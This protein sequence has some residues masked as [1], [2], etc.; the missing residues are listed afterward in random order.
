MSV[1]GSTSANDTVNGAT[2]T[3]TDDDA[4]PGDI[5][6]TL[7]SSAVAESA[8][9]TTITVTAA[10]G[11]STSFP[12]DKAI[13]VAVGASGDG[14]TEG[15]DYSA[16]SDFT[17]T[18]SA[19]SASVTGTFSVDPTE[20]VLDEAD[21]S[22][23]VT[24]STSANDTV[25]SASFNITDNDTSPAVTLTAS[26]T[27]VAEDVASAPTVTVTAAIPVGNNSVT[28]STDIPVTVTVAGSG[29][30]SA[31]DFTPVGNFTITLS[32]GS[33]SA[34]GT[35]VLTPTNDSEDESD[36]TVTVSG[37]ASSPSG[38]ALTVNSDTIT[39]TD[40]DGS[41]AITLT[42]SETTVVED[43]YPAP[44]V[45]V[46]ASIPSSGVKFAADTPVTVTVGASGDGATEG[47]DYS[48]VSDFTITLS[49]GS[50][51]ATGT[52]VLTPTDDYVDETDETVT[53][54]GSASSPSGTALTVNSDTITLTD[55]DDSP[56]ITLD[57]GSVTTV[58][59]NVSPAPTVTVTASIPTGGT[60]AVTFSTDVPV[61]V[62]VAGS[63]TASAVDFAAVSDFTITLS[64]GST[65]ATGTFVLTPADDNMDEADETVTVSGSAEFPSGTSLTVDS[66]TI[67]LTD[68]D[69]APGNIGLSLSSTSVAES[70]SATTITVTAALSGS[71]GFAG[72]V[73]VTV[74]VSGSGTASAVD[75]APVSDFTITLSA[76]STSAT[77]TFVLTPADDNMDETDETVTVSG[78]ASPSFGTATVDSAT[79]AL[80]DDDAAPGAIGLTLSSSAV[81]ESA[82]A[83]TITVTAALGGSTRFAAD[84]AITVAVG[85]SGDGATEG[86]DYSTVADFTITLSAGSS[87][88]TGTFSMDP[89]QDVLD[90]RTG[91]SVSVSGSTSA[92]DTVNGAS[93]T[94]TD[95]DASPGDIGLTL[96]SSAVAESASATTVTVTA[97]LGGSTRFSTDKAITVAV[98]ASGDSATEGTDYDAVSD[99]TITL[100]AGS[101]SVTG[102]FSIDPTQDA[103]D[104]GTGESVSV[105]GSTS[106]YDTVNGATLTITD[107]DAA[108]GDIGLTLSSTSVAE[109]A[110]ATTITVTAALGG[111]SRF[112]ADKAIT[113]AVGASGDGA[114]EGTDYDTVADFT[115][116]LSAGSG[117]VTGTFSIDPTQDVLDEGTG[118]SV[119]VSGSTS[120]NDTVNGATLTITDDDAAPGDIGLTLSSNAV[121]ESASATTITVTAAL[122]GTSRFT[123]DKAITVAVGASGDGATE[124]TDYDAVSD[125]TI[126]LSAGNGS[127]TG[128]FSIDPTQDVLDEGTGESV[129]VSGSTSDSDT[130]NG[131]TLTITD[132]DAAPGAIGLTLSSSAVLESASATTITVTAALGGTSRFTADKAITVAVG[133]SGDGATEGTD[134]STVDDFTITLSAGSGSV[135][136]TFSINPTQDALDEGAGESVSVSGST[137]ES[138]TV[139]GATL[140]ITDDDAAPGDIGLTLSSTSV[141]E[142]AS[143]TTITVTAAL[144]GNS[145]FTADK[146]ITVAVGASGDGATEGTDY[147]TVD[148]FTITLSAGSG[149]V[150]GTFS[151]D[152]TQDALDEGTG[153]SVSVSG[154]TS[155]NDTVN[156]AT[157]TITDDDA[158]PGDIGLTLS[159]SAVLESASATT[160]TVTAAL[161]GNSR[162][163]ADKAITVA[164]G[165]SGDGATEGTDY[166]TVDDFTITLS[167]GSGS[168]T[169]TFSIN[170][171]QDALDEGTGESV[172]VS[173]STSESDT[174]NGATLTITDDDAAPGDIGLTLSSSAVLESASATTITVTAAL[175]G[176]SRFTA[177]KAITVAVGASGDGATEG[178]DYSTVDDFTITLSAGSGSAT[179]TFSINPTQDALDEGTG[180]SVSVSGSTS[181]NDTVN[182]ATLTITDD[183]AAPGD[184][185]L[186][187]SS[188]AVL[189]S[190]SATTITVTAALGGNSRF[191][192]D[193]AITVA[194]GASGD[195]ATEGT[196]YSTVDDFTITLS[197][198]SGSVTGTF[199]IDPTQDALDEGTGE[200]V[201]VSGS[202]SAND[203]VNGATLTITDDDAAPG[204]I[205]LTL[206]SS[207]VL[208]S[209]SATTITVT[210]ALGGNSRF[211][212]DKA[213][214][215]AVGASGDGA[216]EGTDYSTVDDFTITLSAGSGSVTGTFRINPTQDALDEGTGESVSVSGSTSANDTVNAATLTITDDDAAPGDIGLTLSS[217]SVAESAS[218]TTITVTAALGGNSRFTADK[219][220]T[221]AVGAS[222]DGATEGTD[223][224]TVADFTIT[225]SAGSGSVTGTFSIDP[226]QDVL[227]EGTGESV[228]VSGSTS[229]NDT[230][231]GATLTI[232]DDDAAPGDIGLT[233]SSTSVAESASATTITVTAA[234]GGSTRFTTDKAITVAVGASGDGATEGT[235]YSTVDDFT[236]T[237][238][239]G[240]GSATGTFSIDPTQDALDEGTGESVSVSGSTSESDTVNGATL[241]ITDDDAAPGDIT[242]TLSSSAV[243]ESASAT[244]ITVTA[245]LGGNSRFTAD[246]AITVAVGA[247][248]DGATEGTDY[249]TVD[250]FTITLSA[251]SGSVTGTFSIDPTQDAL[252]EGTGESVS[253]SGSTSESDTVN[254]ATLTITDDDAAPGDIGLTLSSS[255]VL[256]SASA[257][258]ITVTAA[259]GGNS[260]FTADKAITV[261]VGASGDGATE[262]TDYSTVD[263]FTITLSAGSGSVTGTFRINPTQDALDEGTGESVSVSGSTSANDTVNAATLTITDDDAAPG[264][265]GLT[266]SS[267]SVAESA[268][269]T[270]I[271]VTAALGGNSRFTAD[272]AITVAVGASGDGATEGTDY[273]TVADFTITLSAGSGSVTGTFSI[274]P[275]Q[276]VLDEGT[277]ESVSVSGSTSAN[278]TVNGATLT[279]TDDDAAPGDIGLTLSSTSV[280]ESAS[281]TTITVTAALGG[282]TRFTTDKAITV[283]VGASGDGA[284]EGTDYSTV[285]DFTITLSAGSGSA[286]GTFSID[287]TQDALDEGT[288]ESVSVSGSTSESDTVNGATLTITDDDAAPGDI[289]LTLSPSS[290]AESASATD[291]TVTAALGGN[292]RF[293]AD[294]AITVAVGASGDGA[295]EGT[296]YSTVADFTITLSAGSGSVT[297]TFSIDPTQDDLDEGDGESVS[298]SGSTSANDTVNGATLEI[299]DDDDAPGAISLTLSKT[300]VGESASATTIT[301]TAAL[302]SNS[303]LFAEDKAIT[304]AVGASGDG[305][306]EGTDYSTVNDFT[307]TLSAGSSSA[308]GTFSID[309]TH[310]VIDEGADE[311]VTVSGSSGSLTVNPATL[312]ITDDD[313]AP[314]GLA[315]A[316]SPNSVLESASATTVTVTARTQGGTTYST[317]KA[318]TVAVG[319]SGDGATE[320]TDYAAVNDFT[321]T[322]SAGSAR[323]TGTFSLTPVDDNVYEGNETVSVSGTSDSLTISPSALTLREDDTKPP[324]SLKL[325]TVTVREN[326]PAVNVTV[327]AELPQNGSTYP[328]DKQITVV[329]GAGGS[330]ATE[331]T[332]YET[333]PDFTVTLSAGSTS[334]TGTFDFTPKDDQ[335]YEPDET[336]RVTGSAD[337]VTVS[338]ATIT[339][340]SDDPEFETPKA[341]SVADVVTD[342]SARQA[343]FTVSLSGESSKIVT[344]DYATSDGTATDGADYTGGSGSLTFAPGDT[345]KTISFSILDDSLDEEDETFAIVLANPVNATLESAAATAVIVDDDDA[346]VLSMADVTVA[347]DAGTA[348]LTASLGGPSGKTVSVD[349]AT[350]DGTA[351]SGSDYE[352]VSGSLTFAPGETEKTI[353]V[354][355]IDD[356]EV[357]SE[358]SFTVKLSGESNVSLADGSALVTIEDDD[359]EKFADRLKKV[360]EAV[361]P[362]ISRAMATSTVSAVVSRVGHSVSRSV[363]NVFGIPVGV[364]RRNFAFARDRGFYHDEFGI[365]EHLYEDPRSWRETLGESFMFSLAGGIDRGV[366]K[367]TPVPAPVEPWVAAPV[368]P[369]SGPMR[370][371]VWVAGDYMRVSGPEHRQIDWDG[372]MLSGHLGAD[373]KIGS[374]IAGAAVSR[375]EG[376]F[377]YTDTG[378]G[379]HNVGGRYTSRMNSVHPYL[380][381]SSSREGSGTW[382]TAGYGSGEI[383]IDDRN[384]GRKSSSDAKL[385]TVAA[386]GTL[387]LLTRGSSA[388]ALKAEAWLSNLKVE[389]N[390]DLI[391]GVEVRTNRVKVALSGSRSLSLGSGTLTPSVELG[392]RR[393][394]GDGYNS[395]DSEVGAGLRYV[396]A[397]RGITVEANGR[398]L[399][400]SREGLGEWGVGGLI[401]YDHGSDRRG[402]MFSA[403]PS[404]GDTASGVEMLWDDRRTGPGGGSRGSLRLETEIGY[405][406]PTLGG[407][408]LITPYGTFVPWNEGNGDSYRVGSR[409]EVGQKLEV[410]LEGRREGRGD[411]VFEH[412]LMLRGSLRW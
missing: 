54:S 26:E 188:S 106:S 137:S 57:T 370:L 34:T 398:R 190:A 108:P 21:E 4:A 191:T 38:T 308:T 147:S 203:T 402:L 165:A 16:V 159:S 136:G 258:T 284:T 302:G 336:V 131:A 278:D 281:A 238:S 246:K 277:G 392:L 312:K 297:G 3:I 223:Y 198:G 102:T 61:T 127:V 93:L 310:D 232:T 262:G 10:L 366:L 357:E 200:S 395:L 205:G 337:G 124:G 342:E 130:V 309:P 225:L 367:K 47:T 403:L 226:T 283:A 318:I 214:T 152:P 20:D 385:W 382:V 235:D 181:A 66:D 155:A 212:A 358:E 325:S 82:S 96:S 211:T 335:D 207:A 167:A 150:T 67:M 184:I 334:V 215:V 129:S 241:T 69:A 371:G 44:T 8:S 244:T 251:G 378:G 202:T 216:T 94:I 389:D 300:S 43:R 186:T 53:V 213:I 222:G 117:S 231:N 217:T 307:I 89:T 120:A 257:T 285:D 218:A 151:I 412:G 263:D 340:E 1:T 253:V 206:S 233:L 320:G 14:A 255:A 99:F 170:P 397:A 111:N 273:S 128:T 400:F 266:L 387:R 369:P 292:S 121:A 174:V 361:L 97:A 109:S 138:D 247:S 408:G 363:Q 74:S 338:S 153:E 339:L 171:T 305:A 290:V 221:V 399:L 322:L 11:G 40:D 386:G 373:V 317:D 362:E 360:N 164:V 230:V 333:V 355:V 291:I 158:A 229:A 220:I 17:I 146:A 46:T 271:T 9:A 19:G 18:L 349:Y 406:I 59:E 393:D 240:S 156:G 113:V 135:T 390:E 133:A 353:S 140:T 77:G 295:T 154:S 261:A 115:I 31:V 279:I 294:K 80:T 87:S 101:G 326:G 12:A 384:I 75:F 119:N 193:K 176:N 321:I 86:T 410:S 160:I 270:T 179:G 274:D 368:E 95:D 345:E 239:A 149:S 329:V 374:M 23:S 105:S 58:A 350:S 299:T 323:A 272:K 259:L 301:V 33:T 276:D 348:E 242:L 169:G 37:S 252:D 311:S 36:E 249:S 269:A 134:Y 27:T 282:S 63:G 144:G 173:G 347:E 280:A 228:S 76:G 196:D 32:A 381:W 267:T 407:T 401:R 243:L 376:A 65:S 356:M 50:T 316:L 306:T 314:A 30:A 201:S 7:S 45:T 56:M 275:T 28:F 48:A 62:T 194:V 372:R 411:G 5:T 204:D 52:F 116:T 234:L 132:D 145:R 177:D 394:G 359:K 25:T 84:K 72:D 332:D 157:L 112:T 141:A 2:L 60:S 163:T 110:S 404:Y 15:T 142:S 182:G 39:I 81:A 405:G 35:F 185:G 197:A 22:V 383:E 161:G 354:R 90:E 330:S 187:L 71:T 166:S 172:S 125:F 118:E 327:T 254:G 209:A 210:A 351:V 64:A 341:L 29:T 313:N 180:E 208:E 148:D 380:G 192:A 315:L 42:A 107:D 365:D 219:A 78:S 286:T 41:P 68:D 344:V 388:L 343:V 103:L 409:L 256:E 265:I 162:F 331:G 83:T 328:D 227:D 364:P 13:T 352:A 264:D 98:G 91:E 143:A 304:V 199:S 224:S 288:G 375:S 346:P 88:V 195:G 178:T 73:A 250:D 260:R 377:D 245:A 55:N 175:G 237:L 298:V 293:A 236:I 6:L 139:N 296:D 85:A 114:T 123:A 268:S 391:R 79:I 289:T 189:E 70:A 287:P 319:A 324:I 183:D 92:N 104:E 396:S 49:A 51:S 379:S 168:V 24:G 126:T 100:S 303:K 122:G 248:G